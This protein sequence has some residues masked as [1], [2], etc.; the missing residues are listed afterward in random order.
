MKKILVIF[1]VV[2]VIAASTIAYF[3]LT[4]KGIRFSGVYSKY[5]DTSIN[6]KQEQFKV[7]LQFLYNEI[8]NNYVN[9]AYKENLYGFEWRQEYEKALVKLNNINTDAEFFDIASEMFY[10]LQDGHTWFTY[11]KDS[12]HS[13][14][15]SLRSVIRVRLIEGRAI[16]VAANTQFSNL[17]GKEIKSI[18]DVSFV[19]I[20]KDVNEKYS[21]KKDSVGLLKSTTSSEFWQYF[22]RNNKA[23]PKTLKF[24]LL[25]DQGAIVEWNLNTEANYS[26]N[27]TSL[28][29]IN[30]GFNNS[31]M[32]S[33]KVLKNNIGYIKLPSFEGNKKAIVS[34]FN[35]IVEDL[36]SKDIKSVIIDIRNNSG[37]NSSFRD[38]LGYLTDKKINIANYRLRKSER[39]KD[40]YYLRELYETLRSDTASKEVDEGYTK[41]FTW[42]VKPN[43]QQFL[44][45]IP[46]ALVVNE[47]I[48][49]S[50]DLFA[51]TC[52]EY[53]LA[54]VIGNTVPLSGF[55]LPTTIA[56]PSGKFKVTYGF[57][58]IRGLEFEH[59]ENVYAEE[60]IT[61]EHKVNDV[62]RG[63]DTQLNDA[64][65]YLGSKLQ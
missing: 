10:K 18:N 30:F 51:K 11:L 64:I 31:N 41:W 59:L 21:R 32:P 44:T 39:L 54:T 60:D 53:D 42:S 4:N 6:N 16:I 24:S 34:S 43:K 38:V 37:G 61:S 5:I 9:L 8:K 62:L 45:T 25:D 49:S 28:K 23:M 27:M 52:L 17:L 2:F 65:M 26:I 35:S 29:S 63:V 14:N 20:I 47:G 15:N 58:E 3:A 13:F 57:F 33:S 46:V 19:D 56:L 48:F 50:A 1:L 36:K 22:Y 12:P 40:I 55:G 7:D